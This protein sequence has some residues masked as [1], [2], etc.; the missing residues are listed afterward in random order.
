MGGRDVSESLQKDRKSERRS[1]GVQAT[2]QIVL[3]MKTPSASSAETSQTNTHSDMS[4]NTSSNNLAGSA[5]VPFAKM[6]HP[7]YKTYEPQ[8]GTTRTRKPGP[9]TLPGQRTSTPE[10]RAGGGDETA[11]S[12]SPQTP[13]AS[14]SPITFWHNRH[15]SPRS[16]HHHFRHLR[17]DRDEGPK[18]TRGIAELP[19]ETI[20]ENIF[21]PHTG[22]VD[23]PFTY[24]PVAVQPEPEIRGEAEHYEQEDVGVVLPEKTRLWR[25]RG[26]LRTVSSMTITGIS[27]E[28]DGPPIPG[29]G[30]SLPRTSTG[31]STLVHT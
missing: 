19:P 18:K 11:S 20:I 31:T 26:K 16:H 13:T 27:K 10:E 21:N 1:I 14:R 24:V 29:R 3:L 15:H 17:K 7:P 23:G 4:R 25:R 5:P 9:T 8:R 22:H 28:G 6:M 12:S 2:N 30:P